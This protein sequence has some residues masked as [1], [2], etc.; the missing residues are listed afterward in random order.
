MGEVQSG[1]SSASLQCTCDKPFSTPHGEK[2][3]VSQ[4]LSRLSRP[5]LCLAQPRLVGTQGQHRQDSGTRNL[6]KQKD[7]SPTKRTVNR[8]CDSPFTGPPDSLRLSSLVPSLH[9]RG[10]SPSPLA[11]FMILSH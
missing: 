6:R 9:A 10:Y 2:G 3:G 4:T 5:S 1:R 11:H 7:S 8:L